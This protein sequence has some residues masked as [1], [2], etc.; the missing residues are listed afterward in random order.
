VLLTLLGTLRYREKYA[1]G[2]P[3]DAGTRTLP[4]SEAPVRSC[5]PT[6]GDDQSPTYKPN[7]PVREFVGRGHIVTGYVLS[8]EGCRPVAGAKLEMWP[9]VEGRGHPDEYRATLFTDPNGRY[10]FESP[11][12][13]H[14]HMRISAHGYTAIFSNSYHPRAGQAEGT[15]N[16]VLRPDPAC[17]RYEATGYAVCGAFLDYW[18]VHGGLAQQGYPISGEFTE[19][20][21]L[22]G[23]PYTVQYFERAVFEYHPENQ[24]PYDVLL[25]QLGTFQYR[26][27]YGAR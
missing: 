12:S 4:A 13:D 21:D 18:K 23:K 5:A 6:F 16:V 9:D 19:Q 22:D 1:S 3:G 20:S 2:A 14:I 25:S 27:K 8:G 11:V 15:F 10:S 24:P 26:E 7:T 17:A